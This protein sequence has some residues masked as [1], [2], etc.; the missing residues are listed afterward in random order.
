MYRRILLL[1]LALSPALVPA[2]VALGIKK[3]TAHRNFEARPFGNDDF[4]YGAFLEFMEGPAGWRLGAMY[5]S[6]LSGPGEVDSVITPELTLLIQDGIWE[7]GISILRDYIDTGVETG[8][9]RIYY[10]VSLGAN[11]PVGPRASIGIH[12]FYPMEKLSN[13][14][15]FSFRDLDYGMVL[16]LRF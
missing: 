11:L 6:G 4:S 3:H 14:S 12:A 7:A 16:R 2:N 9:D 13:I 1:L 5:A 10:Q 8:W 15:D